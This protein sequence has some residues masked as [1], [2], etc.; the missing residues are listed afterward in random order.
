MILVPYLLDNY[1]NAFKYMYYFLYLSNIFKI[2]LVVRYLHG[3]YVS[4]YFLQ[5]I[6]TTTYSNFIWIL[7][8][9][10]KPKE[11]IEDKYSTI[12]IIDGYVFVL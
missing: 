6:I 4:Y 11:Q 9:I 1:F 2:Y 10:N 8:Y 5:W 3:A 7:S 12:E